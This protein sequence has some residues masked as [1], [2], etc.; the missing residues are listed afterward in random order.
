MATP[1]RFS[2]RDAGAFTFYRLDGD[3]GAIVTLNTLKTS[4]VETYGETVYARG[5][6]GN[7]KLVGFSSNREAKITLED[8][9]FDIQA[10]GMITG[11]IVKEGAKDIDYNEIKTVDSANTITLSKKVYGTPIGI[12]ILNDDGTLGQKIEKASTAGAGKYAMNGQVITFHTDVVAGTKLYQL[13]S[14][15][16]FV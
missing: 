12:Y 5:G 6:F 13:C 3:K 14:V 4:G 15:Y 16:H 9:I 1:N 2:L 11:N 7:A 8:A 10:L